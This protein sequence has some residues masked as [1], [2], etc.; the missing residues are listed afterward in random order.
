MSQHRGAEPSG[1][2][3]AVHLHLKDKQHTLKDS[4]M[5]ILDRE[6]RASQREVKEAIDVTVELLL[7]V[8]TNMITFLVSQLIS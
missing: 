7:T 2:N 3:T 4:Q 8:S 6:H 5:K 1:Q